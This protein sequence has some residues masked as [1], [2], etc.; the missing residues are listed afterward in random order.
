MHEKAIDLSALRRLLEVIGGDPDD[1]AELVGDYIGSTPNLAAEICNAAG[2]MDWETVFRTAHTL[3]TNARDFG[4]MRLA[5]L[6]ASLEA[7]AKQGCV[8][9]P[10]AIISEIEIEEAAARQAL[11]E[12]RIEDVLG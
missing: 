9:S 10:E 6:C 7:A 4:A 11:Q 8:E 3:K 2:S 12:I 5:T 1:Y